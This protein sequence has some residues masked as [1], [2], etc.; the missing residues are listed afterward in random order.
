MSQKVAGVS[1]LLVFAIHAYADMRSGPLGEIVWGC[2]LATFVLAGSLLASFRFGIGVGYLFH[3]AIGLP[4][5]LADTATGATAGTGAPAS[6]LLHVY[7]PIVG[8][9]AIARVGLPR[10][11]WIGA[12]ALLLVA[13]IL[14]LFTDPKQ[15]VNLVHQVWEPIAPLFSSIWLY[16]FANLLVAGAFILTA[17]ALTRVV[18]DRRTRR[19]AAA[20]E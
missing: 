6:W 14:A 19:A 16:R 9:W 12:W 7:A 11:A 20:A 8:G 18:L 17:N 1:L 2:Y 10:R 4:G 3:A 15:N 5:Y 13:Q